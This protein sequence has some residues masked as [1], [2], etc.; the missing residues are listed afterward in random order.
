ME[1]KNEKVELKPC[2]FCGSEIE[3]F[4]PEIECENWIGAWTIRCANCFIE[5]E[6]ENKKEL[7]EAWNKRHQMMIGRIDVFY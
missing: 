7:I 5:M 6:N 2:P 3:L 4:R 1:Q